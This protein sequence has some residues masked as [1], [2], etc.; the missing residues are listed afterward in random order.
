[1][2]KMRST[3]RKIRLLNRITFILFIGLFFSSCTS[4]TEI[5]KV[6]YPELFDG[7]YDSE[8]PARSSSEQLE[9]ISNSIRLVNNI[10]FYRTYHFDLKD[11]VTVSSIINDDYKNY[12]ASSTI[13]DET[14]SGTGTLIYSHRD[15]LG[16]LTCAHVINFPDSIKAFHLTE[17]GKKTD[18]LKSFSIIVKQDIYVVP[19]YEEGNFELILQDKE[20]D[21]AILKKKLKSEQLFKVPTISIPLGNAA[22]LNW[23]TFVYVFGFPANY[24]MISKAIVSSPN[25]D[26]KSS[27]IIDAVANQGMSGGIVLAIRDGIPN[28]ELVGMVLS[29]PASYEYVLRPHKESEMVVGSEYKGRLVADAQRNIKFGITKVLSIEAILGFLEKNKSILNKHEIKYDYVFR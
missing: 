9:K 25:Y 19:S 13:F 26:K 1:M 6:T 11:S 15:V 28:F 27:F 21:I 24:K 22:E 12:V 2:K 7:K 20:L 16:I 29:A 4:E 18:F 8:F 3:N 14:A 10:A 5:R 17:S 23:G